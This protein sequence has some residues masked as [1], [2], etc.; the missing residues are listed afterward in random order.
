MVSE[1]ST[2]LLTK[3][4]RKIRDLEIEYLDPGPLDPRWPSADRPT[5]AKAWRLFP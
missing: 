5:E 4:E 2:V 3:D 1:E